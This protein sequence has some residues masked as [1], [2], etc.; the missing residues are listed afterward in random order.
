MEL[1]ICDLCY[2]LIIYCIRL[3]SIVSIGLHFK[4]VFF[5]LLYQPVFIFLFVLW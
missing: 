3:L 4:L 1:Y 5:I 2:Y